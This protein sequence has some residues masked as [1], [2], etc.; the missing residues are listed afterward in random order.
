MRG[1]APHYR[2]A[3]DDAFAVCLTIETRWRGA[4]E[5]ERWAETTHKARC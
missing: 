4:S 3:L 5:H 2:A 1:C